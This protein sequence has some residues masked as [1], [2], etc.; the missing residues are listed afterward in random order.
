MECEAFYVFWAEMGRRMNMRDI[1]ESREAMIE[2]SRV[3]LL[4]SLDIILCISFSL[5]GL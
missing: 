5:A 1:P 2:W 3:C 4:L